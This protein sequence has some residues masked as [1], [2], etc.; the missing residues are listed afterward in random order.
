MTPMVVAAV[1]DRKMH[2]L[3]WLKI[4]AYW[5]ARLVKVLMENICILGLKFCQFNRFDYQPE[6]N[7][8]FCT[9]KQVKFNL[10]YEA[11]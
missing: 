9:N 8:F 11:D 5:Y 1:N 3:L 7:R 4:A 10:P 6:N 2:T